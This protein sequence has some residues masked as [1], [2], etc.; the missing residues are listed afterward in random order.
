MVT[1]FEVTSALHLQCPSRLPEART[2]YI[3]HPVNSERQ[4][5]G[6]EESNQLRFAKDEEIVVRKFGFQL[7]LCAICSVE[8]DSYQGGGCYKSKISCFQGGS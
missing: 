8:W 6:Q 4:L 1:A 2:P 5:G 7:P 3:R